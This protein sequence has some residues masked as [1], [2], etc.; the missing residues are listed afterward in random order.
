MKDLRADF[1]DDYRNN[2]KLQSF[3]GSTEGVEIEKAYN[4][5]LQKQTEKDIKK[6]EKKILNKNKKIDK[7]DTKI[8]KLTDETKN[9]LENE[10]QDIYSLPSENESENP[11]NSTDDDAS[12]DSDEIDYS[13]LYGQ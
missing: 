12:Q 11:S 9:I 1:K 4:E 7:I 3:K 8:Q 5:Y 10:L 6:Y 13:V 2:K